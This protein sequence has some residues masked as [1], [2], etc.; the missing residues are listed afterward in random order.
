MN[1]ISMAYRFEP[2]EPSRRVKGLVIVLALHALLGYALLS[3]MARKGLNL[4]KK[5]LVAVVIQEVMLPPTPPQ[6][7]QSPQSRKVK[8]LE[9]LAPKVQTEQPPV[10]TELPGPSVID[11]AAPARTETPATPK[12]TDIVT[13]EPTPMPTL[14]SAVIQAASMEGE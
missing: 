2:R 9:P 8:A 11:P 12:A 4:I 10:Q 5:P 3:D 13:A 14:N 7:P 1:A 6:S